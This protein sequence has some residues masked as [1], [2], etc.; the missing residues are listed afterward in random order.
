MGSAVFTV[1]LGWHHYQILRVEQADCF[2]AIASHW[3]NVA[4]LVV[5][6]LSVT[7]SL[8]FQLVHVVEGYQRFYG[9]ACED[10]ECSGTLTF[11]GQVK[12]ER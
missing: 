8:E 10:L 4:D 12:E 2:G 11:V 1:E 5:L 6:G 7:V 3:V 9:V